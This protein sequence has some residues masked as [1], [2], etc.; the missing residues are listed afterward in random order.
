MLNSSVGTMFDHN[1]ARISQM[2]HNA[3]PLNKGIS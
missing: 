2:Q 3:V 1:H